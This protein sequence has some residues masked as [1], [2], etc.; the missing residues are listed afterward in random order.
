PNN[1]TAWTERGEISRKR[2]QYADEVRDYTRLLALGAD[3]GPLYEKR[4][5]AYRA[6]N[7][8]DEAIQ[9]YAR[10]IELNPKNLEARASRGELLLGRRR[11][12]EA[13]DEF[14][15]I[16][17]QAPKAAVI[18]RARGIVNWQNLK[19]FDAAL[20]DFAQLAQLAPKDP[21]PHRCIGVILL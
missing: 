11:Y 14:S 3:K 17:E 21:E 15:R 10:V 7:Q 20:A 4:A 5:A 19:D 8:P 9:D 2:K 13:R 18:W 12:A 6:S 1:V 16:L